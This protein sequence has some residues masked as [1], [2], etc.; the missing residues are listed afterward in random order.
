M[1]RKTDRHGDYIYTCCPQWHKRLTDRETIY[2]LYIYTC[3]PQWHE[4][5]TDTETIYILAALNDTKDWQ[6]GRL[7]TDYIQTIYRLYTYLLPSL[8]SWM[9]MRILWHRKSSM[10]KMMMKTIPTM[11]PETHNNNNN[12]NNKLIILVKRCFLTR[13]KLTALYKHLVTKKTP[14]LTY[15]SNKQNLIYC[16]LATIARLQYFRF[17]L[18]EM[19]VHEVFVIRCLYSFI[20][21]C[22]LVP[23]IVNYFRQCPLFKGGGGGEKAWEI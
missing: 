1:T 12:N 17:C 13:V 2:R 20:R 19:Y 7:Y 6:T 10:R 18:Y 14:T 5:L 8:M 4:R 9:A 22:S 23:A 15:I 16:S 3:C 21:T 11:I